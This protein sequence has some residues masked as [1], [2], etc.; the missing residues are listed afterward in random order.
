MFAPYSHGAGAPK[1]KRARPSGSSSTNRGYKVKETWTHEFFCLADKNC[2][3]VPS[4]ALKFQLQSAGLGRK[5]IIFG[6][7]DNPFKLKEKLE[8]MYPKLVNGG[9]FELLRSGVPVH[10][11]VV[12][13]PPPAGYSVAF[14]RDESGLGQALAYVRPLQKNLEI[15]DD[16]VPLSDQ[17]LYIIISF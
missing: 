5:K 17:V 8:E 13:T 1:A 14:L 10:S 2:S 9:G 15:S 7:K 3:T 11:L 6:W 16:I 4:R 12:I